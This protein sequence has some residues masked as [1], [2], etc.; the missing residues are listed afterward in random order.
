MFECCVVRQ[1]MTVAVR[2]VLVY[3]VQLEDEV[4]RAVEE[5]EAHR[6]RVIEHAATATATHASTR[7]P[8]NINT[9]APSAEGGPMSAP[10][11][12]V[13]ALSTSEILMQTEHDCALARERAD[14]LRE[15]MAHLAKAVE[16]ATR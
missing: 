15:A 16:I 12:A 8:T 2:C 1:A 6:L 3:N 5:H 11:A 14:S 7:D 13:A 9:N 4:R 10:A